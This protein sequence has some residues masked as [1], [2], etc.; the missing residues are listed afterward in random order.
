[1]RRKLF[2]LIELLVVIAIIAILASMLLPALSKARA[3]AQSIKC[4]SNMKQLGLCGMIYANDNDDAIVGN[5]GNGDA[6]VVG[7]AYGDGW[8]QLL[9]KS[10][11]QKEILICPSAVGIDAQVNNDTPGVSYTLNG[12]TSSIY[13]GPGVNYNVRRTYAKAGSDKI[14][15]SDNFPG[16]ISGVSWLLFQYPL[17]TSIDGG[18][19]WP[20]WKSYRIKPATHSSGMR[21]NF[22]F[23][24]GHAESLLPREGIVLEHY[25]MPED[26]GGM[27]DN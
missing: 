23:S 15:W 21:C 12:G 9:I 6:F 19:T 2:T 25:F 18:Y 17:P 13:H 1:M 24:D 3:A 14:L 4:V 26:R 22:T 10:G 11:L 16:L 5:F 7:S 8:V 27:T 20:L